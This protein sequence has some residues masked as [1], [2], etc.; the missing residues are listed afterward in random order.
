MAPHTSGS[1]DTSGSTATAGA[2][3][4]SAA[5]RLLLAGGFIFALSAAPLVAA[6]VSAPT[7]PAGPALATCP[8][9]EV[10]DPASGAC[11][12]STMPTTPVP[13]P[14]NPEKIALQPGEIT[15]SLPGDVGSLPEVDGIPC[16]GGAG[17]GG[18]TSECYG[19]SENQSTYKAPHASV[20]GQAV[21][22]TP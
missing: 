5:R 8:T 17:G 6:A 15:S 7:A 13:N 12:P 9:G 2:P 10:L 11:R 16:T 19:L 1:T 3:A 4:T 21:S 22:P 20:N 14:I 18:S